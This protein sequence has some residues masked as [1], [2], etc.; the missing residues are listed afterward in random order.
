[1]LCT[2]ALMSVTV[3]HCVS[4]F[5]YNYFEKLTHWFKNVKHDSTIV[6][7]RLRKPV[8]LGIRNSKQTN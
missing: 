7:K 1:M 8:I 6:P 5:D 2:F 3:L 4:N